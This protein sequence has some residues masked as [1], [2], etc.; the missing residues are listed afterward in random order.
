M[1][2]VQFMSK[3]I[4]MVMKFMTYMQ[5]KIHVLLKGEGV[6][7]ALDMVAVGGVTAPV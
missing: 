4:I 5:N 2:H 6:I 1:Y 7:S 3:C